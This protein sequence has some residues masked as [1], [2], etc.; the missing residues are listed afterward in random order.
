M[1]YKEEK[2][3]SSLFP[4]NICFSTASVRIMRL[5]PGLP[6]FHPFEKTMTIRICYLSMTYQL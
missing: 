4:V 6:K 1:I 5:E 2:K 3:S